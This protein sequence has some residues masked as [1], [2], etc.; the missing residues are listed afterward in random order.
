MRRDLVAARVQAART[1][2]D[3]SADS[4]HDDNASFASASD[5]R[6]EALKLLRDGRIYLRAGNLEKAEECAHAAAELNASYRLLDDTPRQLSADIARAIEQRP[7][8][9]VSDGASASA[10]SFSAEAEAVPMQRPAGTTRDVGKVAQGHLKAA[11]SLMERGDYE[12][13]IEIAH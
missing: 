10:E 11:R 3:T 7:P 1:S 2:N 12:S 8:S 9:V 13:A 4:S 6:K 5:K